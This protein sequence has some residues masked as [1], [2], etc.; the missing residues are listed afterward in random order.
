MHNENGSISTFC[1]FA[2]VPHNLSIEQIGRDGE[3]YDQKIFISYTIDYMVENNILMA[4]KMNNV[5]LPPKRGSPFQLVAESKWGHK[6]TKWIISEVTGRAADTPTMEIRANISLA[7][8]P[9]HNLIWS[10]R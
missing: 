3:K 7:T 2:L 1:V 6:W 5:A 8:E 4:H 10:K 9:C